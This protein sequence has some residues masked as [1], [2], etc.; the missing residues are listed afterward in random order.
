VRYVCTSIQYSLGTSRD[1]HDLHSFRVCPERY[2][3]PYVVLI[4]RY[5]KRGE[6]EKKARTRSIVRKPT[7]PGR[8]RGVTRPSSRPHLTLRAFV[9]RMMHDARDFISNQFRGHASAPLAHLDLVAHLLRK[10]KLPYSPVALLPSRPSFTTQRLKIPSCHA[11]PQPRQPSG[12]GSSGWW[13]GFSWCHF[14]RVLARVCIWK[15]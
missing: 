7:G 4:R 9:R 14:K 12:I 6:E 2:C 1:S 8:E 3:T 13:R 10:A 15:A 11:T 5:V